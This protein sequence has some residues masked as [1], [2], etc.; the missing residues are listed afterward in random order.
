[1]GDE[2]SKQEPKSTEDTKKETQEPQKYSNKEEKK[3]QISQKNNINKIKQENIKIEKVHIT[4]ESNNKIGNINNINFPGMIGGNKYKINNIEE[5]DLDTKSEDIRPSKLYNKIDKS[6]LKNKPIKAPLHKKNDMV[7]KLVKKNKLNIDVGR[8]NFKKIEPINDPM[9]KTADNFHSKK[10]NFENKEPKVREKEDSPK[11]ISPIKNLQN[12][13]KNNN[14]E[15]DNNNINQD[16]LSSRKPIKMIKKFEIPNKQNLMNNFNRENYNTVNNEENNDFPRR[17]RFNALLQKKDII[18]KP[19]ISLNIEENININNN[20]QIKLNNNN[21]IDSI[22]ENI[23]INNE[24]KIKQKETKKIEKKVDEDDDIDSN[25]NINSLIEKK[26]TINKNN[27]N[28]NIQIENKNNEVNQ[29]NFSHNRMRRYNSSANLIPTN[30]TNTPQKI[31]L[32]D[33]YSIFDLFLLILNHNSYINKYLDKNISKIKSS[34]RRNEYCLSSI[35][36]YINKY[37]W[38]T[39]PNS[40]ITQKELENKYNKFINCYLQINCQNMNTETYF[41]NTDNL[42]STIYFILNKINTE[43]TAESKNTPYSCRI[44]DLVLKRFLEDFMKNNKSVISD[45]FTGFYQEGMTCLNCKNRTERYGSLYY[46]YREYSSFHYMYFDLEKIGGQYANQYN[47]Y[48]RRS[49][50]FNFN[51]IPYQNNYNQFSN[52][53]YEIKMNLFDC[54]NQEFGKSFQSPCNICKLN[55]QKYIQKQFYSPPKVLTI[56]LNNKQGNFLVH[57]EINLSKYSNAKGIHNYNLIAILCKYAYN[58]RLIAYCFNYKESE[59]YYYTKMEGYFF[60][61][62]IKKATC[63]EP[64]AIPYVLVYQNIESMDFEYK[65]IDLDSA[66]NKK[67][68]LF[69]F[70]NGF[71]PVTLFFKIN[72]TVREV[73]KELCSYYKMK[74]VKLLVGGNILKDNGILSQVFGNNLFI[75]VISD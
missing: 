11:K 31:F 59:W 71:P 72:A 25:I 30:E 35:L 6:N 51:Q 57:S 43:I 44:N 27:P 49:M 5:Q 47:N 13:F 61:R 39:K 68:Y 28:L 65:K 41:Y 3:K 70:Q 8:N 32:Y 64:N 19:K 23:N 26:Q 7:N 17:R 24:I 10:I 56:I 53:D 58:N 66:N 45:S 54:L 60:N 34:E 52:I 63:L 22:N 16:L 40:I 9:M 20:N 73:T 55:T 37:L 42:V 48:R 1:M 2:Q 29:D 18:Q 12:N 46:P 21:K 15:I 74:N 33:N 38:N 69:K 4:E 50:S 67:G 75:L 14:N 36:Y 62:K